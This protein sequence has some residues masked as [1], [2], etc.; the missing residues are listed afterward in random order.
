MKQLLTKHDRRH[1]TD[2]AWSQK[3]SLSLWPGG[4]KIP[5]HSVVPKAKTEIKRVRVKRSKKRKLVGWVHVT[6]D[7][8]FHNGYHLR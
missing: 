2:V 1:T 8:F 7:F 6:Q 4:L 3:L 5:N